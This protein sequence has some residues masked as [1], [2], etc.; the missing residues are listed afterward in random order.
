MAYRQTSP[1]GDASTNWFAGSSDSESGDS[2]GSEPPIQMPWAAAWATRNSVLGP[3]T[4]SATRSESIVNPTGNISV[5]S[6]SRAPA[7]AAPVMS[8][9][10]CARVAAPSSHTM[11]CWMAATFIEPKA[12]SRVTASDST[13]MRLQNA[14]R[15]KDRPADLSS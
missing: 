11:S 4:G 6:T 7:A 1:A 9:A 13:S 10:T 12:L 15:T 3:S 14:N 5:S 2:S 8:G